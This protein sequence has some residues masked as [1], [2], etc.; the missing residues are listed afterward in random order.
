MRTCNLSTR[1]KIEAHSDF[2]YFRDY[3]KWLQVA[4]WD[5]LNDRSVSLHRERRICDA[6][7]IEPPTPRKRYY[8]PCLPT[9]LTD[10]QKR[11]IMEVA[12][13]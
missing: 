9:T 11:R 7:G 12:N 6:L 3:P 10:D 4:I 2:P 1:R 13:E 5:S 8:R